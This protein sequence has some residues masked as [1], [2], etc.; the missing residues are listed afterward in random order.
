VKAGDGIKALEIVER[1]PIDLVILDVMLP[2][3]DGYE[4]C[5]RLQAKP[6]TAD[7]PVLMISAKSRVEDKATAMRVGAK[8]YL[9]KP[10]GMG[11]LVAAVKELLSDSGDKE[12]GIDGIPVVNE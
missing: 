8:L 11:D 12:G 1:E 4:V 2:G 9:E 3:M 10:F 6:E 5:H 7:I